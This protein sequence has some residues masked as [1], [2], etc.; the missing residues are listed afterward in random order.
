MKEN[1]KRYI[2]LLLAV[3]MVV[4]MVP[5]SAVPAL[6]DTYT[7]NVI[8]PI[9]METAVSEKQLTTDYVSGGDTYRVTM[10]YTPEALIPD[11][12]ELRVSEILPGT[13]EFDAYVAESAGALGW[14]ES[15]VS[16]AKVMDISI[17][18]DG[19]EVQP[20]APVK[21]EMVLVDQPADDW[22][23]V[24]FGSDETQ[25]LDSTADGDAL[26][27]ETDGFSVF[28]FAKGVLEKT[29][30][31][32][33]GNTYRVTM[34]FD[35][36]KAGIPENAELVVK[37]I[38]QEVAADPS[39][40]SEYDEYLSAAE[41]TLGKN[42][43]VTF[44]RFFDIT[45][46][47]DG[48]EIQP[49]APVDVKIELAN[50]ELTAENTEDVKAVHFSA[51]GSVTSVDTN[52]ENQTITFTADGFSVYGFFCAETITVPFVAGDGTSYEVTVTFG[53]DAGIPDDAQLVVEELTVDNSQYSAYAD[54]AAA[55]VGTEVP[56]LSYIKLLDISIVKN[57][58]KITLNAPVDVSIRLMDKEQS[59]NPTVV[60]HFSDDAETPEVISPSV[61]TTTVS[62][63]TQ[64]FSIY[65]IIDGEGLQVPQRTY[66]FVRLNEETG[67]IEPYY[68]YNTAGEKVDNQIIKTGD[69]LE[70]INT[71]FI[72]DEQ[73]W[74]GWR[75][76]NITG[77]DEKYNVEPYATEQNYTSISYGRE[78]VFS[79]PLTVTTTEDVYIIP[80]F[81][82]YHT[83]TFIDYLFNEDKV[84]G[85]LIQNREEVPLGTTYDTTVQTVPSH[86]SAG[87]AGEADLV[88]VGWR[89]LHANSEMTGYFEWN[90]GVLTLKP[91][92]TWDDV[93]PTDTPD[94]HDVPGVTRDANKYVISIEMDPDV[95]R[96]YVLLPVY[97]FAHWVEYYSAPTGSGATY[98]AP[99]HVGV[100]KTAAE[101]GAEPDADMMK[102]KGYEFQYWTT[103]PTFDDNGKPLEFEEGS[104]PEPFD[105]NQIL[106]SDITLNAY[107]KKAQTTY[108]IMYWRQQLADDKS[109]EIPTSEQMAAEGYANNATLKHYDYAGSRTVTGADVDSAVTL[110]TADQN[111]N[112]AIYN[113]EYQKYTGF[114]YSWNDAVGKT[115]NANGSTVVNVYYDRNEITM[116]FDR[117][118]EVYTQTDASSG[119][120]YGLVN[121]EYVRIRWNGTNWVYSTTEPRYVDYTGSRYNSTNGNSGEQWG[122]Y[123]NS[124]VRVYHHY[125]AGRT[126]YDHWSRK[127]THSNRD[128]QY[129]GIRYVEDANGAYGFVN[130]SMIELINGQYQDG[131]QEV[132]HVYNGDR[133]TAT[134]TRSF[135]GL[136]G[137]LLEKYGYR[138]PYEYVWNYQTTGNGSKG[139]SYLG[140]FVL[141]TDVRDTNRLVINLS[142]SGSATNYQQ[143]YLQLPEAT[144]LTNPASYQLNATGSYDFSQY[145]NVNFT[146]SDKYE[147]YTVQGYRRYTGSGENKRYVDNGIIPAAVDDSVT[148]KTTGYY[149]STS[150]N[151]E[152]YYKVYSYNITYKDPIT[153]EELSNKVFNYGQAINNTGKPED[154]VVEAH[155]PKGY[156]WD[157]KWYADPAHEIVFNFDRTMPNHDLE[158]FPGFEPIYYWIKI[159]PNGG[160]LSDTES[161]WFWKQY[162][163]DTVYEYTDVVRNYTVNPDGDYYYHYDEFNTKFARP[164]ETWTGTEDEWDA[165]HQSA[166]RKAEYRLISENPDWLND[167]YDGKRYSSTDLYSL[168]GWYEVTIDENT[169]E[170]LLVPYHFGSPIMHDTTLRAVWIKTGAFATVYKNEGVDASG[171]P[172]YTYTEGDKTYLV[173]ETDGTFTYQDDD[174][175]SVTIADSSALTRLTGSNAPI[176]GKTYED[177]SLTII[178]HRPA[179]PE[180]YVCTGYY[181]NGKVYIPGN[182]FKIDS[183][184]VR[185]DGDPDDPE[186]PDRQFTFYPIYEPISER[187]VQVT[188]IYFDPN[189]S[190]L[191]L[192]TVKLDSS[193]GDKEEDGVPK[194]SVDSSTKVVGFLNRQINGELTLLG[195]GT[196]TREGYTLKGWSLTSG[197]NN[198]IDF[199]LGQ[200]KVAADNLSKTGNTD[201][202]T[203][204]AVWEI[205]EYTVTVEKIVNSEFEWD[206][207]HRFI[208][209]PDFSSMS[210]IT[211]ELQQNFSLTGDTE[212]NSHI[213]TFATKI[214]YGTTFSIKEDEQE[215]W[216]L[217]VSVQ[218]KRDGEEAFG[219]PS[220]IQNNRIL[221]VEGDMKLIFTNTMESVAYITIIKT[222]QNGT[223]Y[224][225]SDKIKN[226]QISYALNGAKF[227]LLR[228]TTSDGS[229]N[230]FSQN[231]EVNRYATLSL[232]QGYY[233]LIETTAPNGY[234]INTNTLEFVIGYSGNVYA[235][236]GQAGFKY[237]LNNN[238]SDGRH[239]VEKGNFIVINHP[240]VA[241]PATGGEG[242]VV[243]TL[244]GVGLMALSALMY[245]MQMKRRKKESEE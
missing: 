25:V 149:S 29:L 238:T 92:V 142:S 147:G 245:S 197:D 146:L 58:E 19:L 62:F 168:D 220:T 28:V 97:Q 89:L 178:L 3:I 30:V 243:Y 233:Q 176:G 12:A 196:Y 57:G 55:A 151:L 81:G 132:E 163:D 169:G 218:I 162:G 129:D 68:F 11:N 158:V 126:G 56:A 177:E 173:T 48:Q 155:I 84:S 174:G 72:P 15:S 127:E 32:S 85:Y 153:R 189:V 50:D 144:D 102:W 98:V 96:N 111:M 190:A 167:S 229:Y 244:C 4:S 219:D 215:K 148:L 70:A 225:T 123:N 27:F 160:Q 104:E 212:K 170:E 76:A 26:S 207:E 66:H 80:Y 21:V 213:K 53:T 17:F 51:D 65:A 211:S 35:S 6:A 100:E 204:Y 105:F 159:E 143:F 242:T 172:L 203:L 184:V 13:P 121:G 179:P 194:Q 201:A 182:V 157:G 87:G 216:S 103:A 208:F 224:D 136:Y 234:N 61:E 165:L 117:D 236:D 88:F 5:S 33:D 141:P 38:L 63:E 140:E 128:Q 9:G 131:T 79:E 83:I 90:D 36:E 14:D 222:D 45:I 23:V 59:E 118:I 130:G 175:N 41:S 34:S 74:S 91:G 228:K 124:I 239:G 16:D 60:V 138:W 49:A 154:S 171:N 54:Q 119:T 195:E 115:V 120:L 31:A 40:S 186:N 231:F 221:T 94:G 2:G 183:N 78:V 181:F 107:W 73:T 106:S 46:L 44:A 110:T 134:T 226:G 206:R 193:L 227:T 112:S 109:A 82:H 75:V 180:G 199:Q 101:E 125:Q 205:K 7:S 209:I 191:D 1:L 135:T 235:Q 99:V 223:S 241:L 200:E 156:L 20:S 217:S 95:S 47:A 39:A 150:Y 139:M 122:V 43:R 133:Y 152:V 214:P 230:I 198:K 240:G 164:D 187:D 137:Q 237:K 22:N 69:S 185:A 232:P 161:T 77:L 93:D 64:G 24:H 114:K 37:E 67:A 18:Y 42:Q 166:T 8:G 108:T 145:Q 210:E 10:T 188:N 202:N 113:D 116:N 71:P 192:E 86:K 52:V